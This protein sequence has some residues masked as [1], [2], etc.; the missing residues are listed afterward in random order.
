M[1]HPTKTLSVIIRAPFF[2]SF[3][4]SLSINLLLSHT[5]NAIL[6]CLSSTNPNTFHI[7]PKTSERMLIV[8]SL[9]WAIRVTITIVQ[10]QLCPNDGYFIS[11]KSTAPYWHQHQRTREISLGAKRLGPEEYHLASSSSTR[12]RSGHCDTFTLTPNEK[13]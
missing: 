13:S 9:D 8:H 7:G 10:Y 12:L 11:I 2:K 1:G 6:L 4:V 5:I 3:H